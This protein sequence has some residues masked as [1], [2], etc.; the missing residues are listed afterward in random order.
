MYPF[1]AAGEGRAARRSPRHPAAGNRSVFSPLSCPGG[2]GRVPGDRLRRLAALQ[3]HRLRLPRLRVVSAGMGCGGRRG[4]T[5]PVGRRGAAASPRVPLR[6][7]ALLAANAAGKRQRCAAPGRSSVPEDSAL[8]PLCCLPPLLPVDVNRRRRRAGNELW[9]P[10][11]MPR[12]EPQLAV[13]GG[14]HA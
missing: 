8:E 12:N 5:R 2:G 1:S 3:Y 4:R 13:A 14:C 11:Q 7:P 9:F 6:V 10:W